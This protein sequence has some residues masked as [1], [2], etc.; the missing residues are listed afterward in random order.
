M[1]RK[2]SL[3]Q[4]YDALVFLSV[5]VARFFHVKFFARRVFRREFHKCRKRNARRHR[6]RRRAV[7]RNPAAVRNSGRLRGRASRRARNGQQARLFRRG[8]NEIHAQ[9]A[10]L[11]RRFLHGFVVL[12]RRHVRGIPVQKRIYAAEHARVKFFVGNLVQIIF[13]YAFFRPQQR[14]DFFRQRGFMS[15]KAAEKRAEQRQNARR[16]PRRF[17]FEKRF[18]FSAFPARF[19]ALLR[20]RRAFKKLFRLCCFRRLFVF[21]FRFLGFHTSPFSS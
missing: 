3:V 18:E 15:E 14:I 5:R 2:R 19:V 6:I 8:G 16:D 4:L 1:F 12:V 11:P 7:P 17:L 10:V 13:L 21:P 20:F 9:P